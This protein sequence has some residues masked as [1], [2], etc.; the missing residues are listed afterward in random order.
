MHPHK[1][2][3]TTHQRVAFKTSTNVSNRS[4]NIKSNVKRVI[5]CFINQLKHMHSRTKMTP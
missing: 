3:Q 4:S 5:P 2:M 1:N